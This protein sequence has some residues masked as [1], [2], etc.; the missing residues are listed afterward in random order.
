MLLNQLSQLAQ[1]WISEI[2]VAR[3]T[4]VVIRRF[5]ACS[6][7]QKDL[8]TSQHHVM[9][10]NR[11][12]HMFSI[13]DFDEFRDFPKAPFIQGDQWKTIGIVEQDATATGLRMEGFNTQEI[14]VKLKDCDF[15]GL[16][17]NQANMLVWDEEEQCS[18]T[19]LEPGGVCV[20][21]PCAFL[22]EV[23]SEVVGACWFKCVTVQ[24]ERLE[25]NGFALRAW[26]V[27]LALH[28]FLTASHQTA[29]PFSASAVVDADRQTQR[30]E[31]T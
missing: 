2:N 17:N 5:Q 31:H 1:R 30:N 25:P 26:I 22:N 23:N 6:N 20:K 28:L 7:D 29:A 13:D 12:F 10:G 15:S 16:I 21:M 27:E 24:V 14:G 9:K 19:K 18:R 4:T 8:Q 3:R 11:S